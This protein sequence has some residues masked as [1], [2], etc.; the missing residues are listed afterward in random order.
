MKW[1]VGWG[2]GADER[3][4]KL[5]WRGGWGHSH[6]HT[7]HSLRSTDTMV[8]EMVCDNSAVRRVF[9]RQAEEVVAAPEA[10]A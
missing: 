1:A 7:N 3:E 4:V 6:T 5:R 8:M 9:E 10:P 2:C